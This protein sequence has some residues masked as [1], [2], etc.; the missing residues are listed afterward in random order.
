MSLS[1]LLQK[2][3]PPTPLFSLGGEDSSKTAVMEPA[4]FWASATLKY[5]KLRNVLSNKHF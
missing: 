1:R 4:T 3:S 2:N 5:M